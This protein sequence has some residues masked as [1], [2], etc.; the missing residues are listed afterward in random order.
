FLADLI[1]IRMRYMEAVQQAQQ[2]MLEGMACSPA[3]DRDHRGNAAP[4]GERAL[5]RDVAGHQTGLGRI[6][7]SARLV[8]VADL[9]AEEAYRLGD[10]VRVATVDLGGARTWLAAALMKD[11]V[12]L[13]VFMVYRQ[14]VRPFTVRLPRP[15][16]AQP[17]GSP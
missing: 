15:G 13:G 2:K 1:G 17:Q 11:D 6:V 7:G 8:Y 3:P 14:E 9:A 4:L 5:G 16:T 12:L 10:P